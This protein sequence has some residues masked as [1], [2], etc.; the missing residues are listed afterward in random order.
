MRR[1]A[2]EYGEL[3]A[4]KPAATANILYQNRAPIRDNPVGLLD[5]ALLPIGIVGVLPCAKLAESAS[6][7]METKSRTGPT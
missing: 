2:A 1:A 6:T 3:R 4:K 5:R 7:M